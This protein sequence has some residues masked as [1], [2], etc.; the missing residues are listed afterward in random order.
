MDLQIKI[1]KLFSFFY[2]FFH[3]ASLF[4][5]WFVVFTNFLVTVFQSLAELN[6][7]C[8]FLFYLTKFFDL[9]NNFLFV[10]F[11]SI[12]KSNLSPKTNNLLIYFLA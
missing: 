8:N 2:I 6:I 12:K 5:F 7:F 4:V 11:I 3:I 9:F 10:A 1:N